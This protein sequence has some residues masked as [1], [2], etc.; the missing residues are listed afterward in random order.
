MDRLAMIEEPKMVEIMVRFFNGRKNCN[1]MDRMAIIL[2]QKKWLKQRL[3]FPIEKK[4]ESM[5]R[6]VII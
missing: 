2:G 1:Y 5:D 3:D 4:I 6:L